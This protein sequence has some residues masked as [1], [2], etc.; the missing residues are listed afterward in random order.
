MT[1][2]STSETAKITLLMTATIN[3]R[4]TIY[5]LRSDPAT[6]LADYQ[7]AMAH[8]LAEPAIGRI[9]FCE[10]S[11]A[12]LDQLRLVAA[13]NNAHG[14]EVVFVSYMAPA[15][16]GARG[17][18]YGEIGILSHVLSLGMLSASE[19]ILKVTGRYAIENF[20]SI[21]ADVRRYE[22][23]D[24]I[25][26]ALLPQKMMP[27]ECFYTNI[28]FLA[29]YFLGKQE[30]INDAE[31]FYF[32]HALAQAVAEAVQEGA[33]HAKFTDPPRILGVSGTTNLPRSVH[34]SSAGVEM[35]LTPDYLA[36]LH[37]TLSDFLQRTGAVQQRLRPSGVS[38]LLDRISPR[39]FL[40]KPS[41]ARAR[42][43][44]ALLDRISPHVSSTSSAAL[45][46]VLFTYD[47]LRAWYDS[48]RAGLREPVNF[49]K[50]TGAPLEV[51]VKL[52]ETINQMLRE[53]RGSR[54]IFAN[55]I[56]RMR[57]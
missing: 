20:D 24:I 48:I 9:I 18:G 53:M 38:A 3:P 52:A 41:V 36:F 28:A 5:V 30:L 55:R 37:S 8:W 14:K 51:S 19:R 22:N 12:S 23:A 31:G 43:A 57:K 56:W 35:A 54:G 13:Q 15:E 42:A 34:K 44:A 4:S 7:T 26:S 25:T 45:V 40:R 29:R 21:L 33:V 47:E 17:K 50:R 16:D 6:R 32:E 46:N 11:G 39:A 27:S 49:V 10:N 2:N 1:G